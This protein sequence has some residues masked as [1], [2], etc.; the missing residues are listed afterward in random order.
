[1]CM[2]YGIDNDNDN[3]T[4]NIKILR[5]LLIKFE[6][7]VSWKCHWKFNLHILFLPNYMKSNVWNL[8]WIWKDFIPLLLMS[9]YKFR[10]FK[11]R[12]QWNKIYTFIITTLFFCILETENPAFN[13]EQY[14]YDMQN[15]H[16]ADRRLTFF[17]TT[18]MLLDDKDHSY[19]IIIDQVWPS[20]HK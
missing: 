7:W 9:I 1:M 13:W 15:A 19:E 20:N 14:Q 12:K 11:Y 3:A 6:I 8:I 2:E 10:N 5:W 4:F 16:N 17:Q 18:H